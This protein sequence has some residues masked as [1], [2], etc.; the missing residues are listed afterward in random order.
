MDRVRP[1]EQVSRARAIQDAN[2]F[3][4]NSIR[5]PKGNAN[6]RDLVLRRKKEYSSLGAKDHANKRRIAK[7]IVSAIESLVSLNSFISRWTCSQLTD[8]AVKKGGRFLKPVPC[9]DYV[10]WDE[11]HRKYHVAPSQG[12]V[13]AS[14]DDVHRCVY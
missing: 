4:G 3:F 14:R 9:S 8:Y 2:H 5:F 11:S 6:Y 1:S 7:E 12:I 13:G 10:S